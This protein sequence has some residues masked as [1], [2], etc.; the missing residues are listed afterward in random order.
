MRVCMLVT[1]TYTHD[2]RVR[3]EAEHLAEL[4]HD[5]H[6]VCTYGGGESVTSHDVGPVKVHRVSLRSRDVPSA[7]AARIHR[8][9]PSRSPTP[10]SVTTASPSKRTRWGGARAAT[11]ARALASPALLAY[12]SSLGRRMARVGTQLAPD[13]VH[14]HDADTLGAAARI[15]AH[16]ARLVY[17]AHELSSHRADVFWWERR[18]DALR[19]RRWIPRAAVT[20]TVSPGIGEI[21]A[22]R[23]AISPVIIRNIPVLRLDGPPYY[24]LREQIGVAPGTR[25]VLHQGQRAPDRGLEALV[26]AMAIVED[27]HLVLLGSA[28]RGMD[29]TL[30]HEA[31]A[32]AV[33]DRVHFL[34][35]IPSDRLLT[36]TAQADVGVTLLEGSSLNHQLAL[37]NKLFEYLAAGVPV[38]ASDLPEI[39]RVLE[40]CGGG[41]VCDPSDSG[42]IAAALQAPSGRPDRERVPTAREELQKLEACYR[43]LGLRDQKRF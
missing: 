15:T 37:P 25:L 5:V 43:T 34:D 8:W 39:R 28:V 23:H 17:D 11:V 29:T 13:V 9:R 31:T 19:E 18:L 30:E 2:S 20:I 6:I 24:D 33:S 38:V 35:A 26:R 32:A 14:A 16:G 10:S 27:A 4:G 3:R 1:T 12:R 42:S 40:A 41:V 7:L 22:D 21:L 36:V